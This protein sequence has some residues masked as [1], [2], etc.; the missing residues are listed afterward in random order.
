MD[1]PRVTSPYAPDLK[2][3][4]D[5]MERL[6][7]ALRFAELITAIVA[8]ISRLCEVNGELTKRLTDLRRKR[9]RS[10]TLERLQRQLLLPLG[11]LGLSAKKRE[12][13]PAQPAKSRKGRHPGRSAFPAHLE[14]VEVTN[15]VPPEQRICPLCGT[16]MTTVGH[17]RCEILSV[18]PAKVFVEV[19]LDERVACPKDDTIVSAPTPP[20]IVERG[21]LSDALIVEGTC[22][23]YIEHTP[24]ERQ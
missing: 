7:R 10:E 13:S 1:S 20:A 12:K 14:R 6:V 5:F 3:V 8:F 22:A 2:E 16:E 24:V 18:V 15:P 4:R 9:P 23:K 19:R 11:E 21:M 17:S